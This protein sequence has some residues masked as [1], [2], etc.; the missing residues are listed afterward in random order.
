MAAGDGRLCPEER[1]HSLGGRGRRFGEEAAWW[2]LGKGGG[3]NGGATALETGSVGVWGVALLV[4]FG[5][6]G[7]IFFRLAKDDSEELEM[8]AEPRT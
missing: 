3:R 7:D 6:L 8:S 2:V 1:F 5:D 4:W